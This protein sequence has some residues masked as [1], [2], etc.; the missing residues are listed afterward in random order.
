MKKALFLLLFM[1]VAATAWATWPSDSVRTKNWSSSEILTEP[2]LEGQFD[3][4]HTYINDAV[5]AS[6]GH[7]HDATTNEGPL[8]FLDDD[9]GVIGIQ[10]VLDANA[11]GTGLA[12]ITDGGVL[13]GSGTGDITPM[14]VLA[15]GEIIVG[16][17][18]TDPVPLGAFTSSTGQLKHESGGIE[19]DISSISTGDILAGA[20]AGVIEIVDGGA[21][22]E[23][24]QLTIQS[25]GTANYETP[26]LGSSGCLLVTATAANPAVWTTEV[27]DVGGDCT[28]TTFTAP[29][30]GKYLI[31]LN[32]DWDVGG[33]ASGNVNCSAS[34]V[35]SNRTY[36]ASSQIGATHYVTG[37]GGQ[38]SINV[39]ADMDATD[40]AVANL[41]NTECD[42][43]N[44]HLSITRLY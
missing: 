32:A 6:S 23:G 40:T 2:D 8:I 28:T 9:T 24:D 17:G 35:T 4:L 7:K 21:S 34:V 42:I 33:G 25:D 14:A 13:L 18:T 12:T 20:S 30:T 27:Y 29:V 31:N 3:V 26:A 44:E 36:S 16:D 5:D 43:T 41:A 38:F 11:G 19:L 37:D 22:A 15:D 1:F 10:G 39:V